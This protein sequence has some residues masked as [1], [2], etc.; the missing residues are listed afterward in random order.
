MGYIT[1]SRTFGPDNFTALLIN[2]GIF[3]FFPVVAK[4]LHVMRHSP[5]RMG[6]WASSFPTMAF[7]NGVIYYSM[8]HP[9][10]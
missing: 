2:A 9:A 1:Y 10:L 8:D 4:V 5:F 3:M 7:A 6:W